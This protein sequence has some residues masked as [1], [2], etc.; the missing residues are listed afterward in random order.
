MSEIYTPTRDE[1]ERRISRYGALK[2]MTTRSKE[3]AGIS[4]EAVDVIFARKLMPVILDDTKN[5]FGSF[6]PIYGA[7]RTTMFI[8]I[9]PPG[10]GP[11]L[12]SQWDLRD[13][14]RARRVHRIPRWR[15]HHAQDHARQVG[16]I[17]LPAFRVPR[18]SQCRN[19]RCGAVDGDYR[20][21]RR[22]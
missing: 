11:C 8:S 3:L 10:Q 21:D 7:A 15:A 9:L 2:E 19:N 1:L 5:P 17:L 12:H 16:R 13:V 20:R 4:Q 18:L 22:A 14:H 6:A